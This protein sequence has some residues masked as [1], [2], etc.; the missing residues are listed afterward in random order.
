M[1]SPCFP[2]PP[3]CFEPVIYTTGSPVVSWKWNF[4][5]S[6]SGSNNYSTLEFPCHQYPSSGDYKAMLAVACANGDAD[7]VLIQV[8]ICAKPVAAFSDSIFG[9]SVQFKDMSHADPVYD[10]ITGWDWNFPGGNPS[11]STIQNPPAV[12]YPAA[13]T[14]TVC[15]VVGS[16][17]ACADTLCKLISVG[18]SAV[19]ENSQSS[20]LQVYPNP[21]SEFTAIDFGNIKRSS[22]DDLCF[23]VCNVLGMEVVFIQ[24]ITA[25]KVQLRRT[26]AAGVY[27]CKILLNGNCIDSG[28]LIAVE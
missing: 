12:T 3:T 7:S 24:N 1:T 6:L 2:G 26:F 11:S 28:K 19:H 23:S 21:F 4:G 8:I 18:T 14:Y 27:F 20:L 22:S 5:D 15:L 13:G 16:S 17:R 9:N 10:Y 25:D